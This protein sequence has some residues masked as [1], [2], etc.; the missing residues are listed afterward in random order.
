M[1]KNLLTPV[2]CVSAIVGTLILSGCGNSAVTPVVTTTPAATTQTAPATSVMTGADI[3]T[4]LTAGGFTFTVEDQA[5][6]I[7]KLMTKDTVSKGTKFKM[8]GTDG[9]NVDVTV[10]ELSKPEKI[11]DLKKEIDAQFAIVKQISPTMNTGFIDVG[12]ENLLVMIS[13]R[14]ADKDLATKVTT[15]IA[16]K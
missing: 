8:K 4:R 2:L 16:K 11:S 5:T 7:A 10:L 12:A 13:Y 6:K 14:T 15:S 3:G 1:R 9:N